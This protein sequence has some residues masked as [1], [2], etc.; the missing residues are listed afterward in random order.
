MFLHCNFMTETSDGNAYWFLMNN[1]RIQEACLYIYVT[2]DRY[3][4]KRI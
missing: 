1:E 3:A 2:T 4:R